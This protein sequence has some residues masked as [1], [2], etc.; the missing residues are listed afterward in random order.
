MPPPRP[1]APVRGSRT[2][3]PIMALF[4]L[5]G[6]RWTL[7]VLWE[8]RD[9]PET[10]RSLRARCAEMSPSVLNTRLREL[11][12]AGIVA[13]ESDGGYALTK[14]GLELR[15]ALKPLD[16]WAKAWSRRQR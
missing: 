3:R 13:P 12:S 7:R 16:D 6:R 9:G 11:R 1:G 4:D 5:L 14:H 2:G 15:G 10:F 8:L